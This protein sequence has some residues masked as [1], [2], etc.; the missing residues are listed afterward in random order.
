MYDP[1]GSFID[2][3]HDVLI[4]LCKKIILFQLV[5]LNPNVIE[6]CVCNKNNNFL[7]DNLSM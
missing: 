1:T 6:C 5:T 3:K 2:Q 4:F 7:T